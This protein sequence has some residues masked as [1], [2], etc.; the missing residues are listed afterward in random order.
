MRNAVAILGAVAAAT[1][2]RRCAETILF[3]VAPLER[4][5]D[6]EGKFTIAGRVRSPDY[7]NTREAIRLVAGGIVRVRIRG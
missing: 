3:S 7:A 2:F 1:W 4:I 6:L 5:D